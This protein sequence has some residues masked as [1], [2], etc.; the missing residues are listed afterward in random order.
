VAKKS[1][2]IL[3]RGYT[4]LNIKYFKIVGSTTDV[5]DAPI[6]SVV[7]QERDIIGGCK[8]REDERK[9]GRFTSLSLDRKD[10]P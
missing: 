3:V 6:D 5:Y 7:G 10:A 4:G 1:L 8:R 2:A 9:L